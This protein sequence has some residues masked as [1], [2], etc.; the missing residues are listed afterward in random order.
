MYRWKSSYKHAHEDLQDARD[1]IAKQKEELSKMLDDD[2]FDK[3]KL[4]FATAAADS[5][6]ARQPSNDNDYEEPVS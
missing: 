3:Q 2:P 6:L 4:D 5:P 1:Q